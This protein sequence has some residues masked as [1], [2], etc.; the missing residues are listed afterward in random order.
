MNDLAAAPASASSGAEL[1]DARRGARRVALRRAVTT[2]DGFRPVSRVPG[3]GASAE[4]TRPSSSSARAA[5]LS[6]R[7]KRDREYVERRR[8][9]VRCSGELL[10]RLEW[11]RAIPVRYGPS[12]PPTSPIPSNQRRER[13]A[14][15]SRVMLLAVIDLGDT[16]RRLARPW[17]PEDLA[18]HYDRASQHGLRRAASPEGAR[19]IP[20]A[21]QGDPAGRNGQHDHPHAPRVAAAS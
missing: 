18:A 9:I 2:T 12:P 8:R 4:P 11:A 6:R 14:A 15:A 7:V 1:G 5:T 13:R 19:P 3:I 17:T 21:G 20:P 16:Y 10:P